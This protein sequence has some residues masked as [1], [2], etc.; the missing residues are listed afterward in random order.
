MELERKEFGAEIKASDEEEGIITGYGSTFGGKPDSYGDIIVE[1]AFSETLA[2]G[3][4]Q[5]LGVSML[6]MH[7]SHAPIGVWPELSENKKGLRVKGEIAT[8]TSLG[9]DA[10]ELS[11]MGAVRGLSIGFNTLEY[12]DDNKKGIRYIKKVDLWEISLVTFPANNRATVTGVKTL[13]EKATTKREL[14][15]SL[16]ECGLSRDAAKYICSLVEPGRFPAEVEEDSGMKEVLASLR[17]A[18]QKLNDW[19]GRAV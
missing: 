5:G 19:D 7:N 15:R 9:S 13:I 17:E 16:R 11:K 2:K 4:A 6:W 10:Y 3:G 8:K 14:E 18:R 12:D 1:G